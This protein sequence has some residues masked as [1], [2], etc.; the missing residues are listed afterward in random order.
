MDAYLE[1]INNK[2]KEMRKA[3]FDKTDQLTLGDLLHKL[4][5]CE[6]KDNKSVY[7]DFAHLEITTFES[8][9][10]Y[11]D[12]LALGF[13]DSG[14]KNLL[15]LI[16]HCQ[17]TIG[18]QFTGWKGGEFIMGKD[19]P[20]WVANPGRTGDTMIVDV[21]DKGWAVLLITQTN[22]DY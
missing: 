13:G 12:E 16:L 19:T 4:N 7:F 17:E 6:M 3:R 15:Q 18:Q 21:V 22:E 2:V 14:G 1:S 11:Y 5:A 10:G 20:V 8:Y 9:R